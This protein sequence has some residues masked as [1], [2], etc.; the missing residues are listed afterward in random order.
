MLP[1]HMVSRK[2]R[3]RLAQWLIEGLRKQ[4][5]HDLGLYYLRGFGQTE[6]EKEAICRENDGG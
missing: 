6:K 5:V 2:K 1:V 3:L 4:M